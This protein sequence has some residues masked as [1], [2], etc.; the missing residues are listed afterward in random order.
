MINTI[1]ATPKRFLAT[2]GALTSVLQS[3]ASWNGLIGGSK[4]ICKEAI[5]VGSKSSCLAE[6]HV[7]FV[8][9]KVHV[10]CWSVVLWANMSELSIIYVYSIVLRVP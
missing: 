2:F 7:P 5:L 9:R 4:H 1:C 6:L 10:G 3:M 8:K